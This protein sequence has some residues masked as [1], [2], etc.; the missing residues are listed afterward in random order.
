MIIERNNPDGDNNGTGFRYSGYAAH[1][2][3]YMA[4]AFKF[5]YSL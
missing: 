1:A 4:Q 5:Q 2:T 3:D